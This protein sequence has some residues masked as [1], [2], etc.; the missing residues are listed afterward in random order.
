MIEYV[1]GDLLSSDCHVIAHQCNCHQTM[2]AG[3]ARQIAN[4][5]PSAWIADKEDPRT[6][7]E[8]LG[9]FTVAAVTDHISGSKLVYNLYGQLLPGAD[10]RYTALRE[11]L[12]SMKQDLKSR[13]LYDRTIGFPK[14]GAGIG[15]GN[16]DEISSI[17]EEV[18]NDRDVKVYV[19]P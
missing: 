6:P 1:R 14:L 16:W 13:N 3:I 5:M 10:T 4:R 19:F 11:A 7:Q 12:Q 9:G 2:G 18:F 8:R 17:I 15:G